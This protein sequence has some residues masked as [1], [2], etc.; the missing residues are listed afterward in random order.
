MT[1]STLFLGSGPFGLHAL[2][3]LAEL[4][5]D[6]HV[7][8]VPDARSG[9][10][11]KT[12]PTPIKVRAQ[13]LGLP[14]SEWATLKGEHGADLLERSKADLVI[15]ADFRLLL[16]RSFLQAP[17]YGSY[18]LHGSILPRWRGASP[19]QRAI[20]AGDTELGVTIYQMVKKLDAGPV[21]EARPV[22]VAFGL[23]AVE[24]EE[25]LSR[26]AADLL[27]DWYPRLRTDDL[28]LVEQNHEEATLAPKLQKAE[29][30][31]D[32][33]HSP[34]E[35][36]RQ[37]RAFEAWPRSFSELVLPAAAAS[38]VFVLESRVEPPGSSLN[39]AEAITPG[40][41]AAGAVIPGMVRVDQNGALFPGEGIPVACG[42]EGTETLWL[43]RL[44]RA[45]KKPLLWSDFLRG[46]P[47]S[48]GSC[49]TQPRKAE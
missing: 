10:G 15:V 39:P 22:S 47:L 8:T 4:D 46:C 5:S 44:Q 38:R 42:P 16:P 49:F 11:S 43:L 2:D 9:R 35:I 14:C 45:G 18:N 20:L 27:V 37:L 28:P 33:T 13:E 6:L 48:T 12:T 31:I 40:A 32:W 30:W 24:A 36:E 34:A 17:N 19:I 23:G 26:A 21:L 7:G 1:S 29:G 25:H 3:R 41:A